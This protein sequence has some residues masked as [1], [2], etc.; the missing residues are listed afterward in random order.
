MIRICRQ[1][2]YPFTNWIYT[3]YQTPN[4]NYDEIAAF[5]ANNG[6]DVVTVNYEA[7][8][9]EN[10]QKLTAK[11]IRVYAH[12]V[13]RM[14][15]FK[16]ML[17]AGC[18]GIYTDYIKPYDLDIVNILSPTVNPIFSKMS[19]RHKVIAPR[20]YISFVET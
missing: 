8:K 6:I 3:L 5:C 10:I 16:M 7:V 19:T 11:G 13:N 2:I 15:D 4:P 18:Y 17:E 1:Q 12:T 14:L 9:K 20:L